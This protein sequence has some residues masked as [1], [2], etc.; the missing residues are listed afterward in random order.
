MN[1]KIEAQEGYRCR[2]CE[3]YEFVFRT[4]AIHVVANFRIAR[5]EILVVLTAIL[6]SPIGLVGESRARH[7]TLAVMS[8]KDLGKASPEPAA[9]IA[10]SR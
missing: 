5:V 10:Q 3:E 1:D 9:E 6:L 2:D 8:E 7:F 4:S